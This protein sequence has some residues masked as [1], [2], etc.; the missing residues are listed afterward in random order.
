MFDQVAIET[1]NDTI[2]KVCHSL[3]KSKN[4]NHIGYDILANSLNEKGYFA[5]N[6]FEV[7]AKNMSKELVDAISKEGYKSMLCCKIAAFGVEYGILRIQMSNA[8]RLWQTSEIA[9]IITLCDL[10]AILLHDKKI[11]FEDL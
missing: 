9:L 1:K 3:S 6:N 2:F 4:I 10:I 7:N 11:K 8:I 5:I